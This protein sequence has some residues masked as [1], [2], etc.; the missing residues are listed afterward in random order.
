MESSGFDYQAFARLRGKDSRKAV[1]WPM[2]V[3]LILF[4]TGLFLMLSQMVSPVG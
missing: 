4:L 2:L 1:N 3:S